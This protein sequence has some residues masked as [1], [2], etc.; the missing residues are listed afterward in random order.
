MEKEN[1]RKGTQHYKI[2]N[3]WKDKAITCDG[4]IVD[5]NDEKYFDTSIEVV[6]DWG[7]PECFACRKFVKQITEDPKYEDWLQDESD[8]GLKAI[9]G[10]KDTKH[11]L[12]RAHIIPFSLGGSENP[13]NLFLLC[14][15]CHKDSPDTNNPKNF[16]RWVYMKRNSP[17]KCQK[18]N[19]LYL[20][21][22][23]NRRLDSTSC[24]EDKM[25]ENI[26]SH[27]GAYSDYTYAMGLADTCNPLP[28]GKVGSIL[29]L[30]QAKYLEDYKKSFKFNV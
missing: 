28:E 15:D 20:N 4:N 11:V 23:L 10:H 12:E 30:I 9:W 21:E 16:F 29:N 26:S 17:N 24:D 2:F 1:V 6:R 18:R 5:V 8:E 14:K 13:D 27:G 19:I 3:Y 7:E 25:L 22:C